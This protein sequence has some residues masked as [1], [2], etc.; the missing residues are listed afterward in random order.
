[1]NTNTMTLPVTL[2]ERWISNLY[3]Y[4]V[5]GEPWPYTPKINRV[6]IRFCYVDQQTRDAAQCL[7]GQAISLWAQALG[8]KSSANTGHAIAFHEAKTPTQPVLCYEDPGRTVWTSYLPADTLAISID[9]SASSSSASSGYLNYDRAGRHTLIISGDVI[10]RGESW[11]IAHEIGHVFGLGHEHVRRDRDQHI[12]YRCDR[13]FGFQNAYNKA[14]NDPPNSHLA[15][16]ELKKALCEDENFGHR[17]GF[18]VGLAFHVRPNF[19]VNSYFDWDSIMLYGSDTAAQNDCRHDIDQ[20]PMLKKDIDPTTGSISYSKFDGGQVPSA[21][22][23][24][25]VRQTYPYIP[26]SP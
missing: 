25:F 13:V 8:G 17:Y 26:P 19:G 2:E 12:E 23:V 3:Q 20:C 16:H 1:M 11:R 18:D 22:D 4:P 14:K 10:S 7:V 21:A 24:A 9:P 15:D 5:G 6:F